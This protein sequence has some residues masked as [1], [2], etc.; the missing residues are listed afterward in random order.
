MSEPDGRPRVPWRGRDALVVVVITVVLVF[1]AALFLPGI[2]LPVLLL[3]QTGVFGGVTLLWAHRHRSVG[4][5]LG[6]RFRVAP[7][8]VLGALGAAGIS[9]VL[10][11]VF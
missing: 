5:L 2:S 6:R 8:P 11:I 7:G 4:A 1:V 9:L 3:I 10:Q